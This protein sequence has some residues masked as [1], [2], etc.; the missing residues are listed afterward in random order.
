MAGRPVRASDAAAVRR[1][2]FHD[3]IMR[4]GGEAYF[5][6]SGPRMWRV[7]AE[8]IIDWLAC[9]VLSEPSLKF[10]PNK[11]TGEEGFL[12]LAA[13]AE[14]ALQTV[15]DKVLAEEV[16][17]EVLF[18]DI[19]VACGAGGCAPTRNG[20]ARCHRLQRALACLFVPLKIVLRSHL[21][22]VPVCVCVSEYS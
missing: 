10:E 8:F 14:T 20:S 5:E 4:Y 12:G 16:A 15:K 18:K 22:G 11:A 7:L 13:N 17:G 6:G 19:F 9:E 21:V 2:R 3:L 1:A